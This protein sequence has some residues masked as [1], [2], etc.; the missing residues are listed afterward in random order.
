MKK[1]QLYNTK[2]HVPTPTLSKIVQEHLFSLG[3]TWESMKHDAIGERFKKYES[4]FK[5]KLLP[6]TFTII[7]IDG[8]NFGTY[9]KNLE[10]PFDDG[11]IKD[12]NLT[13][14]YLCENIM[15]CKLGYTQSDEITLVLTDFD[16]LTSEAWFDG[17]VQKIASVS[18]SYAT[19]KFNQLRMLR[20]ALSEVY[21][22]ADTGREVGRILW[23][24]EIKDF[25]L[26]HFDSRAFN[27][28]HIEEVI[29]CLIWR[30]Q[31]ATRNSISSVAQSLYSHKELDGKNSSELQEMIFQKGI[32]WNDLDEGKKRGRL[33]IKEQYEKEGAIRNKWNVVETPIF[34]TP[35][36][37]EYLRNIILPN[38]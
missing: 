11:L 25:H 29:N 8:K 35:E 36:G 16:S 33:I 1:E 34:S 32:N 37:K 4:T 14:K 17:T 22:D 10:K 13:T 27:V 19:A 30:Q 9:C 26:A 5:Y 31:D 28:P 18:A 24:N 23:W 15:G 2:I 38:N 21:K 12:M 7:R 6:R 3:F 20:K